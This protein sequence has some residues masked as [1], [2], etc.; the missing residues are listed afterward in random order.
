MEA[1]GESE[2]VDRWRHQLERTLGAVPLESELDIAV[3]RDLLLQR[4]ELG[5][6]RRL[7]LF[8]AHPAVSTPVWVI[9][10]LGGL[11]T[12]AFVLLFTDRRE[13]FA[14]QG[15]LIGT[16][17]AMVAASL[18]LVWF[19]DHPYEGHSGSIEPNEMERAI[20]EI[21]RENPELRAPCDE[22]GRPTPA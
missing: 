17:A 9:L 22:A 7:R 4:E 14:V 20:T 1:G 18:T 13:S 6:A 10:A 2:I 16:V 5:D 11:L 3:H 12:I 19:L 15:S 21:E 8:E